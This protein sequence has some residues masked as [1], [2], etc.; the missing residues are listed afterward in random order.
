MAGRWQVSDATKD[1][2][3]VRKSS[4]ETGNSD[5]DHQPVQMHLTSEWIVYDNE[6]WD[7]LGS[8]SQSADAPL[9]AVNSV[10]PSFYYGSN[11]D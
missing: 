11:R 4:V 10:S 6:T 1:H 7:Y 5:W 3:L 2:T 9:V 8:H